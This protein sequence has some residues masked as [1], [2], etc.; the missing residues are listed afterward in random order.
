MRI[1]FCNKYNHP[2]SG[3]EV[4]LFELMD[5][6]RKQGHSVALFS[7]ADPR[8]QST[9]YDK[10]SVPRIDF[11]AKGGLWRKAQRACH[12][13]Y[14]TE[15]R[16]RLRAMIKDPQQHRSAALE[17][18]ESIDDVATADRTGRAATSRRLGRALG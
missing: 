3:T 12:A 14:S 11:K 17:Y 10:Y 8:G 6:L 4:Y 15:A 13:I 5:L 1:L 18:V 9:P 7:M 2:F 16:R